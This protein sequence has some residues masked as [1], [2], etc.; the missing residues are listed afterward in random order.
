MAELRNA[1]T[2]AKWRRSQENTRSRSCSFFADRAR[3]GRLAVSIVLPRGLFTW[4]TLASD[5]KLIVSVQRYLAGGVAT[6]ESFRD[7][8]VSLSAILCPEITHAA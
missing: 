4:S 5:A 7:G 1:A 2:R 6:L 3:C 8:V